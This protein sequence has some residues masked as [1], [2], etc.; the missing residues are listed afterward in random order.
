MF[1]IVLEVKRRKTT[2]E[3]NQKVQIFVLETIVR[4]EIVE[5]ACSL[6]DL[7]PEKD[8][9]NLTISTETM[10]KIF[11]LNTRIKYVQSKVPV[12]E[13]LVEYIVN[14]INKPGLS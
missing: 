11:G 3:I 9:A 14:N 6:E 8:L 2:R 13:K 5:H 10:K 1:F 12:V 4:L 7:F